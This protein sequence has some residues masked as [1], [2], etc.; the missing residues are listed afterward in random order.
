M[1]RLFELDHAPSACVVFLTEGWV[2]WDFPPQAQVVLSSPPPPLVQK[3]KLSTDLLLL[4]L[5]RTSLVIR[6]YDNH[7]CLQT[8]IATK[9]WNLHQMACFVYWLQQILKGSPF[10]CHQ[11]IWCP[12][13]PPV[14]KEPLK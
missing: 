13:I 2:P 10:N 11:M 14:R 9:V 3:S 7:L 6:C 4:K 5:L 1:N 12:Y 8:A